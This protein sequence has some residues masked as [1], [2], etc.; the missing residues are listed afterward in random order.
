[1]PAHSPSDVPAPP[2]SPPL[3]PPLPP[4]LAEP[5]SSAIVPAVPDGDGEAHERI[6]KNG[7]WGIFRMTAK[8]KLPFGGYQA[9]CP[10]HRKN[11]TTDCKRYISLRDDTREERLQVLRQLV[12][13]CTLA[14]YH[15]RQ[16]T[17]LTQPLPE[18]S[19]PT[20]A[21]LAAQ[22]MM[23]RPTRS[24]IQTDIELDT[25]AASAAAAASVEGAASSSAGAQRHGGSVSSFRALGSESTT[26]SECRVRF[27]YL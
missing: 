8:H 24:S 22:I 7:K 23:D 18:E 27:A 11:K 16:R 9:S 2:K 1:M 15:D 20:Y 10:F 13:W 12:W 3:P 6:L 5:M 21:C 17:H 19:I 26:Q 4:P 25:E 14:P